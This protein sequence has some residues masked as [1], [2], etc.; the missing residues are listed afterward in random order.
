MYWK[1]CDSNGDTIREFAH[2]D[3]AVQELAKMPGEW[4]ANW[5]RQQL[6]KGVYCV[7]TID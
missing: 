4:A 6:I 3:D 5:S 7:T 1:L 2:F